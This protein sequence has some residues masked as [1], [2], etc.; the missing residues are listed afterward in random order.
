MINP[1]NTPR[2]SSKRCLI[3]LAIAP[4]IWSPTLHAS[5]ESDI[6][7]PLIQDIDRGI[8]PKTTPVEETK[9]LKNTGEVMHTLRG[10][11]QVSKGVL[12][13]FV[14]FKSVP[15]YANGEYHDDTEIFSIIARP[16]N[17]PSG[18]K[19]PG[20]LLLHGGGGSAQ[21]SGI[22][23]RA[24]GWARAGYVVVACDLPGIAGNKP[25]IS[26]GTW[27]SVPYNQLTAHRFTVTPDLKASWIYTAEATALK[28]FALLQSQPEVDPSKLGIVGESWGGYS[29]TLLCGLLGDRVEAGFSVWGCGFFEEA[30]DF[31]KYVLPDGAMSKF[32]NDPHG[33]AQWLAAFD[34]GR[35]AG[36]I[37]AHFYIAA[38]SNDGFFMPP[39]VTKTYQ[40]ITHAKSKN[41]QT[42]PNTSH[43]ARTPG[44]SQN[45]DGSYIPGKRSFLKMEEA[46]FDYH[47]KGEGK[48]LPQIAV[49]GDPTMMRDGSINIYFAVNADAGL[50]PEKPQLYYSLP[51]EKW[52]QR[53]WLQLDPPAK[54]LKQTATQGQYQVVLPK[55]IVDQE[56]DWFLLVSNVEEGCVPTTV[57]TVTHH[58]TEPLFPALGR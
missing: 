39:P 49:A 3:L 53:K 54:L 44:G 50:K 12:A 41:M 34:A 6:F 48:P 7:A 35:R 22:Y 56:I 43:Q 4:F 11:S 17:V 30:S 10:G 18:Q 57:S 13:K 27:R 55:E 19:L 8:A 26:S 29:T 36:N 24:L 51:T 23:Y 9:I 5:A 52:P 28:A 37:K 33:S 16:E 21:I 15:V 46:F 14:T 42:S 40:A 38:A 45:A 31:Q 25:D 47:L 20:I 2:S 1:F 58:L 32:P